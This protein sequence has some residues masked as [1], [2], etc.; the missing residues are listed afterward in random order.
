MLEKM[1]IYGG[2]KFIVRRGNGENMALFFQNWIQ[3]GVNKVSDLH[4]VDGKLDMIRM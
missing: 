4:F 1:N 3:S 2:N